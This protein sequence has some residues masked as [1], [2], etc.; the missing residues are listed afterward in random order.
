MVKVAV[1]ARKIAE[2]R[3]KW[4][5]TRRGRNKGRDNSTRK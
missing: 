2:K 3:L 4:H 5:G 1:M